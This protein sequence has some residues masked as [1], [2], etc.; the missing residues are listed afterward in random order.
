[1][2]DFARQCAHAGILADNPLATQAETRKEIFLRFYE[3]ELPR[4]LIDQALKRID[5]RYGEHAP[6]GA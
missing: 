6:A 5:E 1:M 4:P 2:Y 3:H